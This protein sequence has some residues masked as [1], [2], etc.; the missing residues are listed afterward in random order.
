MLNLE[1]KKIKTHGAVIIELIRQKNIQYMAEVGVWKSH[2][3]KR[4]LRACDKDLKKYW[5]IDAFQSPGPNHGSVSQRTPEDWQAYYWRCLWYMHWFE[6]LCVV[7]GVS[8]G[9]AELFPDEYFDFIYIDASHYYEDVLA[10]IR[11]WLP[12]MKHDGLM[13]GHDYGDGKHTKQVKQAVVE[14]FGEDR[15]WTHP[16]T[17]WVV[18]LEGGK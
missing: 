17:T 12:K 13:G 7:K 15:V 1:G 4:V 11:G 6:S 9:V 3:V 10:D 14:I 5:A 8:P 18:Q 16:M 2:T